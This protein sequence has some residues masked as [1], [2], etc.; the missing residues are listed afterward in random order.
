MIS[1]GMAKELSEMSETESHISLSEPEEGDA[2]FGTE[3][4]EFGI[5]AERPHQDYINEL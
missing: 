1:K 5:G 2:N 3:K 4:W